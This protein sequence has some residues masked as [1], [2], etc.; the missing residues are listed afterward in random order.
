MKF[1]ITK[2][3]FLDGLQ[4]VQNVVSS[5]AT[6]PILSNVL[7]EADGP[8]LRMTTTD[9][10]VVVSCRVDAE[11]VSSPGSTTLPARRLATIVRELPADEILIDV[12]DDNAAR[13]TCG[14][15]FFRI[16]GLSPDDYPPPPRFEDVKEFKVPAFTLRD[17]LRKVAYAISTDETRYVLNGVY[18]QFKEGKLTLVATDGRRLAINDLGHDLAGGRR[19]TQSHHGVGGG[20]GEIVGRHAPAQ[21][22]QS[23]GRTRPQAAPEREMGQP[24]PP[25]SGE[26]IRH[27]LENASHY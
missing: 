26:I 11:E 1:R 9:L 20:H 2:E 6:L 23:V 16:L 7:L 22:R 10:D 15:S 21:I 12:N 27:S 8:E 25:E 14:N 5:R 17:G 18:C 3:K 24:H 13:I 19:Q 4:Q